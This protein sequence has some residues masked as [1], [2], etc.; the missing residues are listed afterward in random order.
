MRKRHLN[1]CMKG[2]NGQREV[3]K[4]QQNKNKKILKREKWKQKKNYNLIYMIN[5]IK[6][7][8]RWTDTLGRLYDD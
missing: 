7:L 3:R 4:Q 2:D 5:I 6:W 8:I 1:G